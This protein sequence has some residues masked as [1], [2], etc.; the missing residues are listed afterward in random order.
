MRA[1]TERAVASSH[2]AADGG[3]GD[4]SRLRDGDVEAVTLDPVAAVAAI[5]VGAPDGGAGQ[6]FDLVDLSGKAVAVIRI[7]GQ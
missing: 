7:A 4:A 3:G 1:F 2:L 6:L 5:H